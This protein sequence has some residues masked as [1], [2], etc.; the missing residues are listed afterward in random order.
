MNVS[1]TWT[2]VAIFPILLTPLVV[3]TANVIKAL[4][5]TASIALYSDTLG[6]VKLFGDGLVIQIKFFQI[7]ITLHPPCAF[8]YYNAK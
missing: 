4:P 3:Y 5:E 7:C 8:Y 1:E 2:I 6:A